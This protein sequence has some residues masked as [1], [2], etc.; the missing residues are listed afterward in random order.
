MRVIPDVYVIF[1]AILPLLWW[2]SVA[3][4]GGYDARFIGTGSEE[5]RKILN[6]ALG[7][8]ASVVIVSYV[9]RFEPAR[10]YLLI[11]LP[12]AATFDLIVRYS[13]RERL[14][15]LRR[16]YGTRMRRTVA[17]GHVAPVADLAQLLRR[18]PSHGLVIVG[19]CVVGAQDRDEV[20]DIPIYGGLDR[21]AQAVSDAQADTVAVLTSP[22]MN[23]ARLRELAWQ[24]EKTDTDLYVASAL[25]DVAGPRTTIRPVLGL[26]L[27]QIDHPELT[28]FRWV[29]KGLF[30]R[31][32]AAAALVVLAPMLAAIALTIRLDDGGPAIFRQTRVGKDGRPFM[33]YKFRTMVVDAEQRKA[34]LLAHNEGDGL[35]FKMR[36]DPRITRTGRFLRM[37]SLD[38]MPQLWN[39]LK[40]DMSLVG[41]RP[42]L[43][44]EADQYGNYVRRR[45]LVKPGITGLW[46][47]SGGSDLP[48]D[49]AVRLDV[50]Y[51]ENWSLALD[52]QILLKTVSAVIKGSGA[53]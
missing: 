39:V 32:T 46:Q 45:L 30:D 11:A 20:A 33:V 28:G 23:S 1:T 8:A 53:Y 13:L 41:P 6:A 50:R 24:L 7:L 27:L 17:I 16:R 38:E 14:S 22:E 5:F 4:A 2:C 34:E 43:P 49:E 36:T 9:T 26:P 37:Y 35:L 15:R 19:A 51:V 40:G 52:L 31:V 48:W 12:S 3:L 21:V 47:V 25:L 10:G 44:A 29:I 42:A 18:D